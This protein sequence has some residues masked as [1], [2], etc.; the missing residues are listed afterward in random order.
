MLVTIEYTDREALIG[1]EAEHNAKHLFGEHAKVTV[2]PD[3]NEPKDIIYFGIQQ[4]I[5]NEQLAL[6]YDRAAS[7]NKDISQFRNQVIATLT[8]LLDQVIIDNESR[9]T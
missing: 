4:L 7:Y 5:T 2:R 8:D 1:S 9:V 6:L 3:S